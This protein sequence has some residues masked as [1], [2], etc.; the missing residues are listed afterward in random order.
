MN[1]N[2]EIEGMVF[3]AGASGQG[4]RGSVAAGVDIPVRAE[5]R[6]VSASLQE[7]DLVLD[8]SLRPKH[9]NE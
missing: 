2:V 9:L 8:R 5:D 7:D 4:A 3:E 1:G 6:A